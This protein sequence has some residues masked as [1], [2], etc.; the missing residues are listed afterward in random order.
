MKHRMTTGLAATAFAL[1]LVFAS[2]AQ[3][4]DIVSDDVVGMVCDEGNAGTIADD[5]YNVALRRTQF[6]PYWIDLILQHGTS[7]G[8]S[9]VF[10]WGVGGLSDLAGWGGG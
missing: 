1:G 9:G 2:A 3:A 10:G 4:R 5:G 8:L 6:D 7:G